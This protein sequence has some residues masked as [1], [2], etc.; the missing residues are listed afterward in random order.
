MDWNP[1]KIVF[2][3]T[4]T[5]DYL[6]QAVTDISN[7]LQQAPH[8][9]DSQLEY[10][11][12]TKNAWAKLADMLA[13]AVH[14]PPYNI[15]T[16]EQSVPHCLTGTPSPGNQVS[17]SEAA[18]DQRSPQTKS[19][20][21]KAAKE[22]RVPQTKTSASK[23]AIE[24]RASQTK[25]VVQPTTKPTVDPYKKYYPPSTRR[26]PLSLRAQTI[27]HFARKEEAYHIFSKHERRVS[28]DKSITGEHKERWLKSSANKSAV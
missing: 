19:S 10:G 14:I 4:T 16:N 24:Q 9:K 20:A 8:L 27:T 11:D 25:S 28:Y 1:K 15:S 6:K 3:S 2:P 18:I 5:E 13:R 17:T 7:V 12:G 21:S 26:R 23:A 22:Q